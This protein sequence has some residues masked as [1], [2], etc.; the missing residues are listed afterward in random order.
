M[1]LLLNENFIDDEFSTAIGTRFS[2]HSSYVDGRLVVNQARGD[3]RKV[4]VR[5]ASER[6][7]Q[8]LASG[9]ERVIEILNLYVNTGDI[10][11]VEKGDYWTLSDRDG[12]FKAVSLDKRLSTGRCRVTVSKL[13]D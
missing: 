11:V 8:F 4:D 10:A 13:D 2:R 3:E 9:G 12:T 6:Q 5:P 7:I 1:S